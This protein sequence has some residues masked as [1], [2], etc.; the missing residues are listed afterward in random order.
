LEILENCPDDCD[1]SCYR[2]LRNYRNKFEHDLIDRHLGA[3]LL[4]Y[5]L[6][7]IQPSIEKRRLQ[8]SKNLLFE[9]LS[10]QNLPGIELFKNEVINVEGLGDFSTPI[11]IKKNG[12]PIMVIELHNPLTPDEPE[13]QDIKTLKEFSVTIPVI[14]CDELA[15]RRNLPVTTNRIINLIE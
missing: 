15:I 13:D 12:K 10:R 8:S 9:D 6:Y 7:G 11:L 5:L 4:R 3:S 14:L 1:R 2:C